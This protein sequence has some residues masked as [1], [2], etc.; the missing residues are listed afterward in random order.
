MSKPPSSTA[1]TRIAKWLDPRR[2]AAFILRVT[3]SFACTVTLVSTSVNCYI[4]GN[5]A[6]A[7]PAVI[8]GKF[9]AYAVV[10]LVMSIFLLRRAKKHLDDAVP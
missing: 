5:D 4:R 1:S 2:P 7:M 10:G 8:A 9:L 6:A 3:L